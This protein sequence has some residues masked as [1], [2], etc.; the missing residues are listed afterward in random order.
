MKKFGLFLISAFLMVLAS[1]AQSVST[2]NNY[3]STYGH[4]IK[5]NNF[6]SPQTFVSCIYDTHYMTASLQG[7]IL[8]LNFGFGWDE[9]YGYIHKCVLKIDLSS[10]TFYSGYWYRR[11]SGNGTWEHLGRKE[12][13][14]IEDKNGIDLT[15]TGEQ[16]YNRGTKQDLISKIVVS[17]GTEPIANRVIN[18]LYSIQ[19]SYKVK[20]PWQFPDPEL[21]PQKPVEVSKP[22]SYKTITRRTITTKKNTG[23]STSKSSKTKTT[24][25][26]KVGKYVQ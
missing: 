8:T 21:E 26:K 5:T 22:S 17:F 2:L 18:E 25:T 20:E 15:Y 12:E 14:T 24:T 10:A 4:S 11:Y 16:N 3:F 13:I 7:K 19:E 6:F 1:N 23:T 9:K